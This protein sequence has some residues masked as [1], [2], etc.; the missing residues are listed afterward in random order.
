MAALAR[1]DGRRAR[2]DPTG[3]NGPT[4]NLVARP[5]NH[6]DPTL[7]SLNAMEH[8]PHRHRGYVADVGRRARAASRAM[9]RAPSPPRTGR[10]RHGRRDPPRCPR[11]AGGQRGSDLAAA[12]A[13]GHDAAFVDRLALTDKVIESMAAGSSRSPRCPTRSARSRPALPAV[14]HPGGPDARAAGR[15]RH[16]LR[17]ASQRDDRRRRPVHQVRQRHHPARRLRGDPQ[18]P[19]ARRAA[20]AKACVP[21]ACPATRCR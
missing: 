16:H 18:Q 20:S 3:L 11:A 19:G 1:P 10:C 15:H 13:A 9:A 7:P 17:V 8:R 2:A 14:R 4:P 6:P 12:R 5:L 21:P